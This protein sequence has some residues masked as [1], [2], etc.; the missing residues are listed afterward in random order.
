MA[1]NLDAYIAEYW[2]NEA[3]VPFMR[4]NVALGLANT[5]FEAML[6][7]GDTVNRPYGTY[8]QLQSYTRGSSISIPDQTAINEYLTVNT[9]KVA[10][11][12]VDALDKKQGKWDE[13]SKFAKRAGRTLSNDIEQAI[14][15]EYSNAGSYISDQDVGGSGTDS[16]KASV[17]NINNIFTVAGRKLDGYD[18][19]E[20]NRFAVIGGRLK[21]TLRLYT[22]GRETSFGDKVGANGFIGNRFGFDIYYSNNLPFGATWTPD[23]NPSDGDTVTIAGVTFTFESG[24]ITGSGEVNIGGTTA[25][26]LDNLVAAINGT[27]TAG[28][29]YSA[30]SDRDRWKLTKAGITASD[31]TSNITITGYGDIVVS[32]S[33]SDDAWSA[34]TQYPLFGIKGAIDLVVQQKPNVEFR[35]PSDKLGRNVFVW[36][37][38]GKKTFTE[39]ADALTYAKIDASDWV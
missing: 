38:Y 29:D 25:Q 36:T 7:D 3:Q 30:I 22:A 12:Y 23:N 33:E 26:T 27:G 19:P 18:V 24:T 31:G 20:V 32:A 21:E 35:S 39:M 28:T 1:N 13:A 11:M 2:A 8:P 37:L 34:Q 10:P 15:N 9:A 14:L 17:A 5:K 16:F 4:E 6:Q